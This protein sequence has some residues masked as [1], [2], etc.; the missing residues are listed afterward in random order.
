[1][2][3]SKPVSLLPWSLN[4]DVTVISQLLMEMYKEGLN[5]SAQDSWV[6]PMLVSQFPHSS[7]SAMLAY[8]ATGLGGITSK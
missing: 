2:S 6:L 8:F 3:W 1:M 5:T 4:G 7:Q